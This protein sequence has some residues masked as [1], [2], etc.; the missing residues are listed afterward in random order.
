LAES[1][2]D[3]R[4]RIPAVLEDVYV[5]DDTI[6]VSGIPNDWNVNNMTDA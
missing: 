5:K 4:D 3:I 1:N 2:E 6:F